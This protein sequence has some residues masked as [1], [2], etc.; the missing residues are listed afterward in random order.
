MRKALI[1]TLTNKGSFGPKDIS[2][3]TWNSLEDRRWFK[4][5]TLEYKNIVMG[6][7]T[8]NTLQDTPLSD[9]KNFVITNTPDQ[10]TSLKN[11]EFLTYEDFIQRNLET[12]IVVGGLQIAHLF[13]HLIDTI[14]IS[15]HKKVELDGEY[16][17]LDLTPFIV[18]SKEESPTLIKEIYKR[19]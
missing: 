9:R 2:T 12:Y 3:K 13:I 5:I 14:Y 6:R 19:R 18:I 4:E 16:L 1:F 17:N 10:Y 15:H 11:L 7:K 8:F